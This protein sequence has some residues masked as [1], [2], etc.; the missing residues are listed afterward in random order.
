LADP[1]SAIVAI[2][3]HSRH[4]YRRRV[5]LP[6]CETAPDGAVLVY[7][8]QRFLLRSKASP[9]SAAGP[10]IS[11]RS[12]RRPRRRAIQ[13]Y[14]GSMPRPRERARLSQCCQTMV[15]GC[16]RVSGTTSDTYPQGFARGYA[17]S[18]SPVTMQEA[19]RPAGPGTLIMLN[20]SLFGPVPI[21]VTRRTELG[22]KACT[23]RCDNDQILGDRRGGMA[24]P[25]L[26]D[27]TRGRRAVGGLSVLRTM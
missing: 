2:L 9:E 4:Q 21:V 12:R 24:V 10:V 11:G 3:T 22:R 13:G 14:T 18:E 23:E 19:D 6:R 25:K 20:A 15:A 7:E 8:N 26:R 17:Y 5:V 1:V 27:L 16:R